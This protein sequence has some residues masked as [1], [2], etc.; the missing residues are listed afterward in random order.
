METS[1]Q[2]LAHAWQ[3]HQAGDIR[4]AEATYLQVIQSDPLNHHAW[5]YLGIACHDRRDFDG[6]V[7]AYRRALEIK[8]QFPVALSNMANSLN[9]LGRSDEAEQS[10]RAALKF[11]PDYASAHTNLGAAL[12][13]QGKLNE[14]AEAFQQSLRFNPQ[15]AVAHGNLGAAR[16]K[17]GRF[18]EACALSQ[19]ALQLNPGY[20]E[21]HRNQALVWLLMGD[22]E[23]GWPEYE[24]RWHCSDLVLPKYPQPRWDGSPLAGKTILLHAEQ[25]LGDTLHLVRY[26]K[27]LSGRGARVIFACQPPLKKLLAGC[28]GID[29]LIAIGEPAPPFDVYSPLYSVP[30]ALETNLSSIPADVPYLH[31]DARLVDQ[32]QAKLA[33]WPEFK[34]GIAWQGSPSH[35]ADRQRSFPLSL[36]A[37]L[38]KLPGVKLFSLQRGYGSE[39]IEQ[40][41]DQFHVH[42]FRGEFDDA[43]GAFVDTAAVMQNLDLVI[44]S[45]TSVAHLAG[46]LGVPVWVAIS[47]A[48]DWRW[49]LDR[50][51][52]P[53]YPTMRLFRQTSPGDWQDVFA[54]ISAALQTEFLSKRTAAAPRPQRGDAPSGAPLSSI[55]VEIAPGELIDKITILQIKAE[56]I[57]DAQKLR[58]VRVELDT[59]L[60]CR[61][62]SLSP[63]PELAE[64]TAGLKQVNEALWDIEDAIRDCE[65]ASDFGPKF[66]ALARSVYRQNDRR[67]ALKRQI[68]DLLGSRLIEE[69]SYADYE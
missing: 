36:F 30:G 67:A 62:A 1:A 22:F 53:W 55:T 14:A 47:V 24:W 40:V 63:T 57:D 69:K 26:A 10:C 44:T 58:N 32:W 9:A 51:D 37:P 38:A 7:A 65:R 59:L 29:T 41:A 12:V 31:V 2:I 39:Q 35:N 5:C 49:L 43:H 60:H 18:E 16:M 23:R 8:P 25:G 11:K 61:D 13:K 52:S 19:Q 4:G 50:D 42:Q 56:R 34:I 28:A 64:L 33:D 21:A 68:N 17:Q 27:V 48:P 20:A 45:D 54:R 3:A 66:V 46:G 6:A 15:D